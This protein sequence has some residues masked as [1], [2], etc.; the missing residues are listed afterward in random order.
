MISGMNFY[1]TYPHV[2][3]AP[4]M[5]GSSLTVSICQTYCTDMSKFTCVAVYHRPPDYCFATWI[6]VEDDIDLYS[7][8][9][10]NDTDFTEYIRKCLW[11]WR[12]VSGLPI[13]LTGWRLGPQ[14]LGGLRQRCIIFLT[15]I[16]LSHLCC[17]NVL[18]FLSNPSVIVLT[19][20]HSI[21]EYCRI[22]N[23]PHHPRLYANRSHTLP[24][25]SSREGGN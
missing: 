17:H 2:T 18:Y 14:N 15:L 19:Q 3:W 6:R 23:T 5:T 4:T 1:P 22:L 20:L 10:T 13:S 24:S 16:G 11:T 25:S 8:F 7:Q 9:Y 12:A 21:S